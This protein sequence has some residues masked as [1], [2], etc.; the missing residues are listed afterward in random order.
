MDGSLGRASEENVRS[1]EEI[2]IRNINHHSHDTESD[3]QKKERKM[4]MLKFRPLTA[5]DVEVRI[6]TVKKNGVQLLLYKD[7]R[8]DQ[9]VLDE[10]VGVENWQKK[11]EMIGGN[12][13]CS[14]GILVDRGAG[15]K[16][17]IWKQDVGVESYTEKEKGQASDAFKRACFC[18]GI[19]RELYTAPFIWIPA[20]RCEIKQVTDDKYTCYERF[21]VKNMQVVC[22]KITALSIANDKG[23][24]VYRMGAI[25]IQDV[26]QQATKTGTSRP[27]PILVEETE[28]NIIKAELARTGVT[29]SQ[30]CEAYHIT[31]LKE[32]SMNQFYNCKS[33][34]KASKTKEEK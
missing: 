29:E 13:F 2:A 26:A 1:P 15:I 22:G 19:G 30:I 28:I 24:E 5:D 9:N 7:A 21:R 27:T 6:S 17:W 33:R 10:S 3:W 12:L 25:A 32:M 14:V 34:L 23:I 20:D 16:E 8:V 11:Y 4:D 18:W 31:N